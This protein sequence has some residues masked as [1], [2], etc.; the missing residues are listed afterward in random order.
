MLPEYNNA[1]TINT[2]VL[3]SK[4]FPIDESAGMIDNLEAV[5][6]AVEIILDVNRFESPILP[7][8][9]GNE[10][11]NL[12]GEPM[13]FA[14]IES[15]RYIKE[16]LKQDDRITDVVDFEFTE[17]GGALLASYRVVTIYGDFTRETEVSL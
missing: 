7:W 12:I 8:S 11:R 10:M 2:E 6:Q 13:D 16:A 5:K 1:V 9:F 4:T 15:E 14:A 17:N 3:P